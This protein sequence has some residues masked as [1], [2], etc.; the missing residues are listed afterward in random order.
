MKP[1][2]LLAQAKELQN[3]IKNIDDLNRENLIELNKKLLKMQ[4]EVSENL[5]KI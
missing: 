4:I 2:L 5:E 3:F 1:V